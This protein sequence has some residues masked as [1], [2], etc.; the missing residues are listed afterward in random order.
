MQ[1]LLQIEP[2]TYDYLDIDKGTSN[3]YGFIAQQVRDI[4]PEAITILAEF[5]P[6]ILEYGIYNNNIITFP[7]N[8]NIILNEGDFIRIDYNKS[9]GNHCEILKVNSIKSF[10]IKKIDIEIPI[11]AEVYVYGT[12]VKDFHTVD[13]NYIYTLNVCATQELHRRIEAQN[14]RIK[15]LEAKI[16]RLLSL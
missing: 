9:K 10:E 8:T 5:I 14:D 2:K 6:N 12:M 3:V 13:K 11:D 4:L 15:E 1:L 16:D 7:N